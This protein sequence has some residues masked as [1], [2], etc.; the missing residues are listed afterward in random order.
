MKK[1]KKQKL[2]DGEYRISVGVKQKL[3]KLN[4]NFSQIFLLYLKPL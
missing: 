1:H 4:K 3:D 2:K